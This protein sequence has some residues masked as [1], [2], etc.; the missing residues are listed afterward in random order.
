MTHAL[1]LA[2]QWLTG[3]GYAGLFG[4]IFIESFGIP[5]PGQ[6]ALM[7]GA[8]LARSGDMDIVMVFALAWAAAFSGDTLGY[9]IG[10]YWGRKALDRLPIS[11]INIAKVERSYH[12]YGGAFIVLARFIDGF[13]QINGIVAGS[14]SMEWKAFL[15][16]NAIG[17]F[18]WCSLWGLGLYYA[19]NTILHVWQLMQPLLHTFGWIVAGAMLVA[20]LIYLLWHIRQNRK[21]G[22]NKA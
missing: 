14:L 18:L 19:A 4:V 15:L 21:N 17:A 1:S 13:R 9:M 3:Y 16:F 12:R 10:R 20:G 22:A 6:A 5:A 7:G 11:S 2:H 8:L